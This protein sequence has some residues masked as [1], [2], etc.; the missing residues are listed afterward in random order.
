[1]I[2]YYCYIYLHLLYVYIEHIP[3][4]VYINVFVWQVWS[5]S[6]DPPGT[7]AFACSAAVARIPLL[8]MYPVWIA[9]TS[10]VIQPR[11]PGWRRATATHRGKSRRN[12]R[13]SW[14]RMM[15]FVPVS[16]IVQRTI[17]SC[18]PGTPSKSSVF[19]TRSRPASTST[20]R[21]TQTRRTRMKSLEILNYSSIWPASPQPH[22]KSCQWP[23]TI[24][25]PHQRWYYIFIIWSCGWES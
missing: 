2:E 24:L 1:M 5:A 11:S 17:N 19:W 4:N 23:T 13:G 21:R 20:S 3:T 9:V 6:M 14:A 22:L 8:L 12:A 18:Q 7:C 10:T 16:Y 15:N 25:P